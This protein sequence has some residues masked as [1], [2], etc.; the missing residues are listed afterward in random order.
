MR[1]TLLTLLMLMALA[2]LQTS[3]QTPVDSSLKVKHV[4][5]LRF[6]SGDT[7]RF[8]QLD[9]LARTVK[10]DNDVYKLTN[11]LIAPYSE[12]L[13][14]VRAIFIWI[15]QN[16]AYD[17][18][19]FNTG[20]DP[21][22]LDCDGSVDCTLKIQAWK[23]EYLDNVLK[24]KKAICFGY[25]L[26]MQ[27]MC[28]IAGVQC[29]IV[30][31]Y[32]RGQYYEVGH[33]FYANHAWNAVRINGQNYFMDACW[34]A[35]TSIEDEDSGKLIGF[36]RQYRNFYW[37]TPFEQLKKNHYPEDSIWVYD[38]HFTRQDFSNNP[39]YASWIVAD[40]DLLSPAS[41]VIPAK[42]GDTLHFKFR[43]KGS[44]NYLQVN[45]NAY[46]NPSIYIEKG[47]GK[48]KLIALD[49]WALKKQKYVTFKKDG[50]LYEFDYVV[51]NA[52][53]DYIDLLFDYERV[54]RFRVKVAYE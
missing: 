3:A 24:K 25:A 16:I 46:R 31:G 32:A 9:S 38:K 13:Y 34:A 12:D 4:D 11:E 30:N 51:A 27:K 43:F 50:D 42:V 14:K 21:R 33:S 49:D 19:L 1:L 7:L 36:Q 2:L 23:R 29:F 45:S 35:G 17:Y 41:G 5:T 44:F 40:L 22:G 28:E 37:L 54:M 26:L 18:K 8:R 52:S 53:E 15:S 20:K 6:G 48:N 39:Y 10:Y 47:K